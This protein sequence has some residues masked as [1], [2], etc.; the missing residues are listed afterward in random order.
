MGQALLKEVAK[1]KEW[2]HFSGE[3]EYDHMEFIRGIEMIK[4]D[5]ELPDRLVTA[6]FNTFFTRSSHR[7]Y[8]KLR[9]A[10]GHQSWTLWKT[11]II[12]KWS[13]YA[14]M[15]K[16]EMAFESAK[17]NADKDKALPWFCQQKDRLTEF[18]PDISEFMI[19]RNILR[20]FKGD[21]EHAFKSRTT[22]QSSA[23][24]IINILQEVTTRTRIGSSRVN[25]K[26]RQTT[27]SKVA[28]VN[29]ELERSK[30]EQL[31][32]AEISLHLTDIQESE[33]SALLYDHKEEFASDKE[34]LG[35]IVG[36]EADIILNIERPYPPLSRR[37]AYPAG[38]KSREA[39]EIHM[40]K[41]LDLGV[42]RKIIDDKPVKGPICFISRQI[43][44]AEARYG[45][46]QME[47]LCLFWAL[48]KLNYFLEGI[49][50][51]V[52]TDCTAVKELLN[53]KTPNRHMLRWQT[54]IQE[55]RGNMNIV[56]KDG[57]IHKNG[58]GLS[59][60]PLSNNIENPAYV[61]EEASPQIPIEGI[62]VTDLNTTFFEEVTSSY[63]QDKNCSIL[64]QLLTKDC[65]DKSLIHVLDEIW[66]KL[67]DEGRFH[68][69]DDIIY[70]RTKHTCVIT[71]V[72]RSL[73][74][75]VIKE[76]HDSPFSGHLS[77]DRARE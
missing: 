10:H 56:H 65:K 66:R 15:V 40:K 61:P 1:L 2:P 22:E 42:I 34:P 32:E 77:E 30:S 27:V 11:Q 33:L 52:I 7:W 60:W 35:V 19:H 41:L 58:D 39:L 8:I 67:Y 64:C 75:L 31:N 37:P 14:W 29:I 53:M 68:L 59:R 25:L 62:S 46:S 21:L 45:A 71:V 24:D 76:C 20:Q 17:F 49:G 44:P 54:A 69:L 73:I 74:N 13:S 18:Y 26:T 43:K 6:M 48:E 9:Q 4:E 38:P 63:N 51:E 55:Y 70:H 72:D 28:P 57:N 36:H 5:F 50:F 23:E 3:G 47:C 16:V 12:N